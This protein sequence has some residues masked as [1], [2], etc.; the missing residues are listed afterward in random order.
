[1][2]LQRGPE[3]RIGQF[4][5]HAAKFLGDLAHLLDI[6]LVAGDVVTP[7]DERVVDVAFELGHRENSFG[8]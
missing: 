4:D 3:F 7:V 1:M 8:G 5:R 6:P 2:L